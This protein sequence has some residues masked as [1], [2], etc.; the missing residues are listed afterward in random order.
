MI[1]FIDKIVSS[2]EGDKDILAPCKLLRSVLIRCKKKP[3]EEAKM[4]SQALVDDFKDDAKDLQK[5]DTSMFEKRTNEYVKQ[6]DLLK[7]CNG[8][9]KEI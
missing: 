2:F 1:V 3:Y 4:M 9:P 6:L 7:M 8:I 5:F